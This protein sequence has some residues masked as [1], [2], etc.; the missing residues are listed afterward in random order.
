MADRVPEAGQ[1]SLARPAVILHYCVD[2]SGKESTRGERAITAAGY[3]ASEARWAQLER[4]WAATLKEARAEYFHAT[5]FFSYSG[6]FRW[7]RDNPA[8]HHRLA[9]LFALASYTVLPY[10]FSSSLDLNHFNP[11]F[12]RACRRL[13]TPHDRIPA[14]MVVVAEVCAQVAQRALPPGGP[15][16]QLFLE[17][18][19]G[20]GEILAWL[21]H[22][23]EVGEGWT[24]AFV[25]FASRPGSDYSLQ[26]ADYLAHE[27]WKEAT[28]LMRNASRTWHDARDEFKLLTT[29]PT[30][31]RPELGTAKVDVRYATEEHFRRSAPQLAAFI[32]AHPEYR[33]PPWTLRWRRNTRQWFRAFGRKAGGFARSKAKRFWYGYLRQGKRKNRRR[34]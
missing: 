7:L 20:V 27:T 4:I 26:A 17:A 32:A 34:R 13:K 14:A 22:L 21:R 3:I 9:T 25:G 5:E 12:S 6:P 33:K 16:A 1:E 29:G 10:G 8:E 31:A 11:I 18:G 24:G 23:K 15:K 2:V 19:D 30:M 28:Q